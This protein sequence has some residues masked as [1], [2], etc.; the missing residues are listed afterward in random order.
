MAWFR[1]TQSEPLPVT[2]A[3]VTLGTRVLVAGARDTTFA[4][5]L[6]SK[7]GLTG[8]ACVV[9]ADAERA[10]FAALAIERDGALAEVTSAPW[11][12]LPYDDGSFDLAV[13]H[14]V[15]SA[16]PAD[17]RSRAASELLRVVRPGGRV[18]I[19]ETAPRAGFG[20]LLHRQPI[21]ATYAS[22][23]GGVNTLAKAGFAAVRELAERDGIR[24]IEGIK[25]A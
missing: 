10:T 1:K 14:D 15:L 16:V 20:A 23:G 4:A 11:D 3:G 19:V 18:L 17:V 7:A 8:R 13:V 12:R 2:M 24:Y 6:A 25:R 21:D 5:A 22:A 9:D